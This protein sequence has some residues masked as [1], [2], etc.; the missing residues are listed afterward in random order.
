MAAFCSACGQPLAP[1]VKFCSQ[2]GAATSPADRVPPPP[3]AIAS[4]STPK[5][6]TCGVGSLHLEKRF[7]MSTPFVTI[8]YILIQSL[9]FV[10]ICVIAIFKIADLPSSDGSSLATAMMFL[11]AVSGFVSGLLG[12]LLL[13]KK[14][15]LS[16]GHCAA[17]V[18]ASLRTFTLRKL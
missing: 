14:K 4:Q 15:V 3:P 6:R 5:C 7:R 12:W 17:I 11:L 16:C 10:I 18:P 9:V 2:C 8:G 1:G 13:M